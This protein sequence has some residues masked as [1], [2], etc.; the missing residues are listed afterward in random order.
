MLTVPDRVDGRGSAQYRKATVQ[1]SLS[2]G[3]DA[4]LLM[5]NLC[6]PA[7]EGHVAI[8]VLDLNRN[9]VGDMPKSTHKKR[10]S[11]VG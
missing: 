9:P 6:V 2:D 4:R 11:L 5:I 7:E 1:Q 8:C 10:C 3:N